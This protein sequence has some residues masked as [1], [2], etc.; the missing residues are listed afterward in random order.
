MLHVSQTR[1]DLMRT[2]GDA[3]LPRLPNATSESDSSVCVLI[4]GLQ[5]AKDRYG[6][7]SG[8]VG[9]SVTRAGANVQ[10]VRHDKRGVRRREARRARRRREY[11][12]RHAAAG[13]RLCTRTCGQVSRTAPDKLLCDSPRGQRWR[14]GQSA[15]LPLRERS[16]F[17]RSNE[18][19][20]GELHP[21]VHS[22][23]RARS[24]H[25]R[26]RRRHCLQRFYGVADLLLLACGEPVRVATTKAIRFMH[27]QKTADL[28]KRETTMLRVLDKCNPPHGVV[29]V[30]TIACIGPVGRREEPLS[31]VVCI[32]QDRVR[33][34]SLRLG[35]THHHSGKVLSRAHSGHCSPYACSSCVASC[36]TSLLA[37]SDWATVSCP[38]VISRSAPAVL[39]SSP[40]YGHSRSHPNCSAASSAAHGCGSK[41][42]T[43]AACTSVVMLPPFAPRETSKTAY[44]PASRSPRRSAGRA[45]SCWDAPADEVLPTA[46][47]RA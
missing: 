42:C 14:Q 36:A 24:E 21:L 18:R 44:W 16:A 40:W 37:C 38:A 1:K 13:L 7:A 29:S 32:G 26:E 46:R 45:D 17:E 5:R 34:E 9:R 6:A 15:G 41:P 31:L 20:L 39:N 2:A 8:V 3:M 11:S 27:P 22:I 43:S 28:G 23:C 4:E 33:R 35:R 12:R 30:E 10:P 19:A 25:A 47:T